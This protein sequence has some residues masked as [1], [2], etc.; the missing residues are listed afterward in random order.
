MAG[1]RLTK[2]IQELTKAAVGRPFVLVIEKAHRAAPTTG[3]FVYKGDNMA[4]WHTLGLLENGRLLTE[5]SWKMDF[6]D[7]GCAP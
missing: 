4:P 3:V 6:D 7:P 1:T 5:R 2:A